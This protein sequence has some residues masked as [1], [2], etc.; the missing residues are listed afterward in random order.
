MVEFGLIASDSQFKGAAN[1]DSVRQR[2]KAG[3]GTDEY[4]LRHEFVTLVD[5]YSRI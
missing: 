4:G 3:F 2:A 1:L 5:A